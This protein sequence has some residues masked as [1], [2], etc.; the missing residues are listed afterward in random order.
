MQPVD[1]D[2]RELLSQPDGKTGPCLWVV[3][4]RL[5]KLEKEFVNQAKT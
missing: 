2:I 3:H 4:N 1:A 5:Q